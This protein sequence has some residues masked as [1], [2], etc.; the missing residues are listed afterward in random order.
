[1][2]RNQPRQWCIGDK[3]QESDMERK[4]QTEATEL[5]DEELEATNGGVF[6]FVRAFIIWG[7]GTQDGGGTGNN[8][9]TW[10]TTAT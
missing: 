1:M 3:K 10:V 9:Q 8:P 4:Y 2:S 7:S 6:R 5:T